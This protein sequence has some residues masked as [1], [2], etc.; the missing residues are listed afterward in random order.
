MPED[1]QL[2]GKSA[3]ASCRGAYRKKTEIEL[4]LERAFAA[5]FGRHQDVGQVRRARRRLA[6]SEGRG[7]R[8]ARNDR[9]LP[10]PDPR[11]PLRKHSRN[12]PK[13]KDRPKR[14]S[15]KNHSPVRLKPIPPHPP[16][17]FFPPLPLAPP[18]HP[19]PS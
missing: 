7:P 5:G 11:A 4:H 14:M 8:V 13:R 19:P 3:A 18:P 6:L 15:H 1:P 10:S 12:L 16:H 2:L 9:C 17:T